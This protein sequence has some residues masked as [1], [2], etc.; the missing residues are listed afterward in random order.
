MFNNTFKHD[1]IRKY[2]IFF[3]S[4][5]NDIELLRDDNSSDG[6]QKLKVPLNYGNKE[7]FL[8]RLE[9]NPDLEREVAIQ[10]P[11]MSF[12]LNN[13]QYDPSRKLSATSRISSVST[14]PNKFKY[15]YNPVPYNLN[16]SLYIMV[17][18]AED[19]TRI[20][21]QIIPFFTPEYTG[22]LKLN[23]DLDKNYDVPL[24][25]NSVTNSD[26]YEGDFIQRRALIWTLNFTLKGWLFGPTRESSIIKQVEIN[27]KHP[28]GEIEFSNSTDPNVAE[29]VVKPGLT[30]EGL[31][32][33]N[34]NISIDKNLIE[35]T[36]NYGF[37][38]DLTE[39]I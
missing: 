20:V 27:I 7:K 28:N 5:F 23:K 2:I 17:K 37:I 10:L 8:A 18:N 15:Q 33:S 26:T 16:I 39:N 19:G 32:T 9:G 30:E 38:R 35:S 22:S 31:P 34:S 1:T 29:I 4:L 14:D 3:G 6:Q 12:E 21:E 11:R 25:L 36:D 24:I 13:F